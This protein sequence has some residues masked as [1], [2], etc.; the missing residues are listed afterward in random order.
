M[1]D[2]PLDAARGI[3]NALVIAVPVWLIIAILLWRFT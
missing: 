3:L 2:D 1:N